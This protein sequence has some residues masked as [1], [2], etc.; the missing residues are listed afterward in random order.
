[1]ESVLDSAEYQD[2]QGRCYSLEGALP[3]LLT[4]ASFGYE[5]RKDGSAHRFSALEED[6]PSVLWSGSVPPSRTVLSPFSSPGTLSEPLPEVDAERLLP[7]KKNRGNRRRKSTIQQ[8]GRSSVKSQK[9][10]GKKKME[11]P[12]GSSSFVRNMKLPDHY[13]TSPWSDQRLEDASRKLG[14]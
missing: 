1:M 7:A 12:C 11:S 9:R 10:V 14:H 8:S 4:A 2:T 5:C 3:G 6:P 13:H